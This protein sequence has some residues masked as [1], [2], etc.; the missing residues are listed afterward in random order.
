MARP[1]WVQADADGPQ[2]ILGIKA[3]FLVEI[4]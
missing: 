3:Y 1:R 4:G 2:H